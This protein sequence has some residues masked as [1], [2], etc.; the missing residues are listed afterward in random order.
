[1]GL[2]FI[3]TDNQ[4]SLSIGNYMPEQFG[5]LIRQMLMK[6]PIPHLLLVCTGFHSNLW[7]FLWVCSVSELSAFRALTCYYRNRCFRRRG[8]FLHC[9]L[10]TC[11]LNQF[12]LLFIRLSCNGNAIIKKFTP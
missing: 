6:T 3:G 5:L 8:I 7:P 2:R 10:S 4:R 1:M 12:I 11:F 9:F